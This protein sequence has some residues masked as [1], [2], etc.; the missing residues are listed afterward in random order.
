MLVDPVAAGTYS[1]V[2]LN[3]LTVDN[4]GG[5]N[6]A[7]GPAYRNLDLR[8]GYRVRRVGQGKSLDLFLEAFNVMNDP[9]FANPTGDMRS[10]SFLVPDA[11][12]GG[13]FPRQFQIGARFGF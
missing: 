13:G 6:G 5:R 2:G 3:A 11:L 9:N 1:G 4:E 10:G 7:R 8:V 12:A